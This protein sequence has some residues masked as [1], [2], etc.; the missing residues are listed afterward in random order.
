VI[1]TTTWTGT[2]ATSV[3]F[4]LVAAEGTVLAPGQYRIEA[5]TADRLL[6]SKSFTVR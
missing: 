5:K 1:V 3:A 2:G 6:G 4:R